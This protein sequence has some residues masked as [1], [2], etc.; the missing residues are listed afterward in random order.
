[1]TANTQRTHSLLPLGHELVRRAVPALDLVIRGAVADVRA[2]P[3]ILDDTGTV[4]VQMFRQLPTIS[5]WI[6]SIV[7]TLA[8]EAGG[9]DAVH[10]FMRATM[11]HVHYAVNFELNHRKVFWVDESLAWM[12]LQTNLD[13]EGRALEL[14]FPCFAIA[15]QDEASLELARGHC[16]RAPHP[17]AGGAPVR[18]L[19]VYVTRGPRTA[20]GVD[21]DLSFVTDHGPQSMPL[22]FIRTMHVRDADDLDTILDSVGSDQKHTPETRTPELGRLT[23]LVINAILYATS[24]LPP[25]GWPLLAAPS[26]VIVSK[27]RGRGARRRAAA[28]HRAEL[29]RPSRS[30]ASAF[31]L[32]GKISISRFRELRAAERHD[33]G[34]AL[35]SRFMVRGHWRRPPA[36]WTDQRLRWIEPYWKG[37]EMA[38]V[39]EREYRMTV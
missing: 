31:L 27:A 25:E 14:P 16:A 28:A 8:D 34:R 3:T 36:M 38:T 22:V 13:I 32:P 12:L 10:R 37:P 19:T 23:R 35:F 2:D 17:I 7:R 9:L 30:S 15:L 26:A 33:A 39:I 5:A 6:K 20:E 29:L 18:S 4:P 11:F 21:L 24:A 1:M